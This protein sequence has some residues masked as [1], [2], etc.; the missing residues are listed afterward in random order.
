MRV[1]SLLFATVAL[2]DQAAA[3]PGKPKAGGKNCGKPEEGDDF[4]TDA[5]NSTRRL[6]GKKCATGGM[7]F[8]V[9][10]ESGK[11]MFY[12][13]GK[14]KDGIVVEME[15]LT[16][17]DANGLPVGTGKEGKHSFKNF[18]KQ[19][20]SISEMV[21]S[22]YNGIKAYQ[23]TFA[24]NLGP[25]NF[26]VDMFLMMANGTIT[27]GD[28]EIAVTAGQFKFTFTTEGWQYCNGT[29][30]AETDATYCA[31]KKKEPEV[32]EMLEFE[33][34]IKSKGKPKAK[35][36]SGKAGKRPPKEG[37]KHK[38]A[39]VDLGGGASLQLSSKVEVDGTWV[40]IYETSYVT[41]TVLKVYSTSPVV[42]W[43]SAT[44]SPT[45]A[46]VVSAVPSGDPTDERTQSTVITIEA[47]PG[48]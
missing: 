37:G 24:A 20:F 44:T 26:T 39:E 18:K 16:E 46:P 3:K 30:A 8:E 15:S 27:N 45:N 47:R 22:E 31:N 28:E 32:G 6:A 23:S 9:K 12:Q 38:P 33:L 14:R 17:I 25:G 34:K 29:A 7:Q 2:F 4:P 35:G 43:T 21:E 36:K 41:F 40:D 1:L 5:T 13:E 19:P 42:Q 10:G 48:V 11:M